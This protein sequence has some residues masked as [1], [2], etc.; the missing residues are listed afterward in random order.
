MSEQEAATEVQTT[1]TAPESA[2]LSPP[3]ASSIIPEEGFIPAEVNNVFEDEVVDEAML[4]GEDV[5]PETQEKPAEDKPSEEEEKPA[6]P[7]AKDE[8]DPAAEEKKDEEGGKEEEE[9][10][11]AASD[12]DGSGKPPKGFVPLQALKEE[13]A[14]R[15]ELSQQL[16]ELQEAVEL[17]GK[18]EAG[19][20]KDD[21][22]VLSEEE[23]ETLIEEDPQEALRYQ[24]RLQRHQAKQKAVALAT[25][26]EE[27]SVSDG[28]VALQQVLPDIYDE[29]SS[30]AT[31][32]ADFAVEKGF[33]PDYLT[34]LTDPRTKII[35]PDGKEKVV[36][37]VGAASVVK[38]LTELKAAASVSEADLR[39][40]MEKE[41]TEEVTKKILAKMKGD[42]TQ[43]SINDL[44]GAPEE[45][46]GDTILTE[47]EMARLPKAELEAYM[48]GG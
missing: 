42:A 23:V 25:R 20:E 29:G 17:L 36:L 35:S 11:P 31:E 30:S 41:I 38:M 3:D 12:E 27:A 45:I 47:E 8:E 6:D 46:R 40:S 28:V 22:T 5:D 15:K 13:R 10:K 33:N 14:K 34:L 39:E 48:R 18:P 21:F 1:D 26:A 16:I 19:Q 37:G 9:E 24:V 7:P 43:I 2:Q 32:L 4:R 44:P